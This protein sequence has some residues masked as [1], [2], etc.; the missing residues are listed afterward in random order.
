MAKAEGWLSKKKYADGLTWVYRYYT[1]RSGDGKRVE[2]AARVGLVSE[3][4]EEQ[5]WDQIEKLGLQR[6]I[7]NSF[8]INPKFQDI[9]EHWRKHELRKPGQIGRKAS[10]T[11]DRDE[12][13]LDDHVLPRWRTTLVSAMTP[14]EVE[15]WFEYLAITPQ[16]KRH[17]PL[18]WTTIG[19]VRSCMSQVFAH[20]QRNKLIPATLEANPLRSPKLGGARCKSGSRY[21]AK[22]VTP[23][24]MVSI[25]EYLDKPETQLEWVL[26]LAC[27]ATA[28]RAEEVFGLKWGDIAWDQNLIYIRRAWSKGKLT[29]GKTEESMTSVALHPILAAQLLRWR[30]ESLY[31]TDEDWL[32]PSYRRKGRIPRSAS[33]AAKGYL[34]PAAKAAGVDVGGRF[35]WHNLRHSLSTF[36]AGQVDP[37]VTMKSLRHK[38]LATTLELYTHA[39]DAQV[40]A[41]ELFLRAIGMGKPTESSET[42]GWRCGLRVKQKARKAG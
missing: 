4:S 7:D 6:L 42:A 29:G 30:R 32:F 24:Q 40:K 25:L 9:A 15:A 20:A 2:R 1:L 14:V 35:G 37:A 18:K 16:G 21:Q 17:R 5:A 3:L 39:G 13:N 34:R 41:Q 10:E 27:A 26:A 19:K 23:H 33:T 12:H 31:S 36:L 22:I 11:A 28:L 8:P 38:R